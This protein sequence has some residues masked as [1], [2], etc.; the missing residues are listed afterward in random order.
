M[1]FSSLFFIYVFFAVFLVFYFKVAHGIKA[2]N[3]VIIIFSLLFYA[4]GDPAY[5]VLLLCSTI[6][7]YVSGRLIDMY[8]DKFMAKFVF[9]LS[10]VVNIGMLMVFKY[11]GFI[12]E[13]INS[14][15]SLDLY[16]PDIKLPIGISFYTFQAMSYTIDC[17]WDSVKVQ[18]NYFRFLM[19]ISLFPQ[20]V[21]G[22]IVR[23]SDIEDEL[24]D[25]TSTMEDIS[26]GITRIIIGLAKKAILA[27]S[28]YP[29][30]QNFFDKKDISTLSVV[31]TWY[32]VILYAMYVYFDFSGY[33][34]MAIGMGRIMGF[35]FNENFNYPFLCKDVTEFWQR[36]HI[37]LG[38][39]FRDYL[40]YI[41][42]FGKR[43][44]TLNLFIVWFC[45]GLWHG[46]SWN[47][48][49]WGLYFGVF[50]YIERL[51]GKKRMKKIPAVVK[52]I[53]NKIVIVVGF[54]IFYFENLKNLGTFFGNLV[55]L[56]H[57][58]FIDETIKASFVNNIFLIVAALIGCFPVKNLFKTD[59]DSSELKIASFGTLRIAYTVVLLAVS[60]ILLVDSTNSPFLYFRF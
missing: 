14:I 46:A 23:Y 37:S 57:N 6:L 13:N 45:T 2:K 18:K 19:Y 53:F 1:V 11:T 12:M 24:S 32:A 36:W 43:I 28:L 10:L 56:N 47:F 16:V 3:A 38:S 40:L 54:G 48:V 44:P 29:I 7:N 26:D 9:G 25:R 58:A 55:G 27:D 21:A 15:F 42:V 41:P 35:H 5:I 30:V 52:H 39:F 22:P 51:I 17:H 60:T 4:W 31:S 49:L 34:D 8:R 50:I 33:S 20:L 59:D